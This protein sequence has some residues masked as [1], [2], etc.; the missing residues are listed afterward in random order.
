MLQLLPPFLVHDYKSLSPAAAAHVT[1]MVVSRTGATATAAGSFPLI[2]L[3]GWVPPASAATSAEVP[4]SVGFLQDGQRASSSSLSRVTPGDTWTEGAQAKAFRIPSSR[5]VC[6]RFCPNLPPSWSLLLAP[7]TAAPGGTSVHKWGLWHWWPWSAQMRA[8][9][10]WAGTDV[11]VWR[12]CGGCSTTSSSTSYPGH[13]VFFHQ[14]P[15]LVRPH[16]S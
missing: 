14:L 15:H 7:S 4:P 10:H 16:A 8:G 13:H 9:P 3:C 12:C 2:S 1:G 5:S 11:R 6:A